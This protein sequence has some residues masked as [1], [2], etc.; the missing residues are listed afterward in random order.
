MRTARPQSAELMIVVGDK[1]LSSWSL[2]PWL[3]LYATGYPFR[4]RK[5]RLDRPDTKDKLRAV[6]PTGKVPALIDG[7]LVLWESLA[8]CETIAEWFPQVGLWPADVATRAVCRS[9]AVEMHGGFAALRQEMPMNLRLRTSKTPSAAVQ[10]D[11]DRIT[12]VWRTCREKFGGAGKLL[13]GGLTLADCMYAPVVTRFRSYGVTLDAVSQAY[14]EA[15]LALPAMQAW[16]ADA[17]REA[18]KD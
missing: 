6:S 2:R 13:F 17:E 14:C 1:N 8:I 18:S 3:A 12:Q 5:I 4:E 9:V 16:Y 7:D 11:I 10:A 15:V